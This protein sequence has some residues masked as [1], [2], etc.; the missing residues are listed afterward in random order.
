MA[1]MVLSTMS[2]LDYYIEP[3]FLFKMSFCYVKYGEESILNKP[4]KPYEDYM[5]DKFPSGEVLEN[6]YIKF[7][8]KY[9]FKS[10]I[11]L[12]ISNDNSLIYDK[13]NNKKDIR[14]GL[15]IYYPLQFNI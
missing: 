11:S 3:K 1:V 10:N 5:K 9:W 4:Y 14:I 12:L 6:K 13:R 2:G 8:V 15:D 7:Y